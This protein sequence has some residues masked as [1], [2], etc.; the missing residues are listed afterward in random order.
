ML[1]KPWGT[2]SDLREGYDSWAEACRSFLN[3]PSLSPRLRCVINS[4]ELLHRCSDEKT[5]DYELRENAK[6]NPSLAK[7][8]RIERSVPGYDAEEELAI[9]EDDDGDDNTLNDGDVGVFDATA[10]IRSGLKDVNMVDI[11]INVLRIRGRFSDNIA[12]S[13]NLNET[14]AE[15]SHEDL[16]IVDNNIRPHGSRD[17]Y[18]LK[19]W[20]TIITARKS[21]V[22]KNSAMAEISALDAYVDSENNIQNCTSLEAGAINVD[23]FEEFTEALNE[24]K[25]KHIFWFVTI[26]EGIDLKTMTN[27]LNCCS[28][29]PV[30]EELVNPGSLSSFVNTLNVHLNATLSS[31]WRPQE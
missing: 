29:F 6:S 18:L 16:M 5:L 31:Y 30:Q 21:V 14:V 3:D 1:F 10:I 28:F 24:N 26:G 19:E 20:Q 27:L 9:F 15:C 23:P 2:F 11:A 13:F 25:R 12:S 8:R 7:F 4:I 22:Q 17:D